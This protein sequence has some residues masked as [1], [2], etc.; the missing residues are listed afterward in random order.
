[1]LYTIPDYYKEF[2]CIAD[3]CEDTCCA[4]WQ[5]VIDKKSLNKYKHLKSDYGKTVRKKV[6]WFTGTFKQ[7]KNKRCAFLNDCNLCDLYL[8]EG[9]GI[10]CK[11]CHLY[12]R[13]IE[14]FEGVREISLSI[15]CPEAARI[16]MNKA[17][18]VEYLTYEKEGEEE[19][20]DFDPFLF[21]ML[22]DARK[23]M[24]DILQN[25]DL[26][27]GVRVVLVLGMAHDIQGRINRQELFDCFSVM[28]KYGTKKAEQFATKFHLENGDAAKR[29]VFAREQFDKLYQL[30]LLKE[31]WDAL[32]LESEVLLY[33]KGVD[34][35]KDA[36][37][38]FSDDKELAS[39]VT[40]QMEQLLV[41]FIFTY[42]PG[43]VYDGELYS[44]I[45]MS[46]YCVLMIYELWLARY[47]KNEG[48]LSMD[49]RIDLVYRFSREVEHS[50]KNRNKLEEMV[51][52]PWK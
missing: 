10:F 49:E 17:D 15:S 42:M 34:H 14:E 32:L 2:Q 37:R 35:Y 5:I 21:S 29:Y 41:Y 47:L 18:K 20:E 7:D 50:D 22:E 1:M 16:L 24:L 6:N 52:R 33:S 46:V 31:D 11:T 48:S 12:P 8:N 4:G 43:A 30:E 3:Q 38:A 23:E 45:Q 39:E 28:D 27:I 9:D 40:I 13:H 25:R 19:Y 36:V 26:P 51:K 44:K